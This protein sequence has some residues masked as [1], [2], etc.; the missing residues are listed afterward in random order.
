MRV[1]VHGLPIEDGDGAPDMDLSGLPF[2]GAVVIGR[3]TFSTSV[4]SSL[5]QWLG[6]LGMEDEVHHIES[7][8]DD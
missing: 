6:F 4:E 7:T 5:T 3:K 1:K 8:L 2:R